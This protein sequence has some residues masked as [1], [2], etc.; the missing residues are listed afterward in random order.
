MENNNLKNGGWKFRMTEWRGF[1]QATME[2]H[3][4]DLREIKTDMKDLRSDLKELN[5]KLSR[6]QIK[7]ASVGATVAIIASVCFHYFL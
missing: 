7:V 2:D 4:K 3:G 5:G 1:M 6:M